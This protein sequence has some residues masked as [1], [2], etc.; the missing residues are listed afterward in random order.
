MSTSP[1]PLWLPRPPE[2]GQTPEYAILAAL[3]ATLQLTT[4]TLIAQHPEICDQDPGR[5][6]LP[7]GSPAAIAAMICFSIADVQDL[8]S[9]YRAA[10]DLENTEPPVTV[11]VPF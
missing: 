10:V 2:I 11:D 3:E 7:S 6:R 5:P 1:S 4:F 8:I 9:C